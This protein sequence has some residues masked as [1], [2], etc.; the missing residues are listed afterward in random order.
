MEFIAEKPGGMLYSFILRITGLKSVYIQKALLMAMTTEG[1]L[2]LLCIQA[3][4]DL[5]PTFQVVVTC[6]SC[7]PTD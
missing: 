3:N 5:I 1:F 6:F 4:D 2:V 7:S